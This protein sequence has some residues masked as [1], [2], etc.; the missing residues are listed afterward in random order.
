MSS[1]HDAIPATT[2]MFKAMAHP[3]RLRLLELIGS[4]PMTASMLAERT[5]ESTGSTSYHLR[6]LERHG[7]IREDTTRG[8]KRERWWVST[9]PRQLTAEVLRSDPAAARVLGESMIGRWTRQLE[10]FYTAVVSGAL[11]QEIADASGIARTRLHL[12]TGE[13]GAL[14][15]ELA[16]LLERW[17]DDPAHTDPTRDGA[18]PVI[19]L[20][21]VFPDIEDTE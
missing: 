18:R 11:P 17:H 2:D 4:T 5:G 8:T 6:Q 7:L 16:D 10:D 1:L 9:G 20:A 15:G 14:S 12:T 13:M 19:S 21:A 3:L